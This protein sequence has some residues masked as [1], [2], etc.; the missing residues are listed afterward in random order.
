M[1]GDDGEGLSRLE[2]G[3]TDLT[4]TLHHDGGMEVVFAVKAVAMEDIRD[5]SNLAEKRLIQTALTAPGD[6]DTYP[7]MVQLKYKT[8]AEGHMQCEY[9]SD[10]ARI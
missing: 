8:T 9:S 6:F 5:H 7:P 10:I 3:V 1:R 4:G 2:L